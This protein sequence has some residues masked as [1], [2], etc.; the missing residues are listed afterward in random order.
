MKKSKIVFIFLFIIVVLSVFFLLNYRNN[1]NQLYTK[2][3]EVLVS[4]KKNIKLVGNSNDHYEFDIQ[5]D[6]EDSNLIENVDI[7]INKNDDFSC[8]RQK[9]TNKKIIYKCVG[10]VDNSDVTDLKRKI[11]V[12]YKLNNKKYKKKIEIKLKKTQL[13][14]KE[15]HKDKV[16]LESSKKSEL[17][18]TSSV[19]QQIIYASYAKYDEIVA[20]YNGSDGY[21]NNWYTEDSKEDVENYIKSVDHEKTID[22]QNEVDQYVIELTNRISKLQYRLANYELLN[23]KIEEY[24]TSDGYKNNW[25]TE[26]SKED[27]ENYIKS[28]DHEKTI[29]KQNE[30]DQYVIELTNRISKLQYR[31]ANY[32]LLNNKIE[33]YETSDEYK[34]NWYTDDSREEV[35]GYIESFNLNITIDNQEIV[36]DYLYELTNRVARLKL[37]L[38]SYEELNNIIYNYRES[39]EYINNWYTDEDVDSLDKF[40]SSLNYNVTINHQEIVNQ[41]VIEL[42]DRV[43]KL[44]YRLANYE[45]LNNKIE[46]YETSDGYKN[47][48]YTDD[49]RE[50]VEGYI[51]SLDL[52]ITIDNQEI[53]DDYLYELTNKVA[54]LEYKDA[55]YDQLD[56]KILEYHSSDEYINN[57][58]TDESQQIV[59]DFISDIDYNLKINDQ[60]LVDGYVEQLV[61]KIN[62]LQLKSLYIFKRPT[63]SGRITAAYGYSL[64]QFHDGIDIAVPYGMPIYSVGEGVVYRT[65]QN[66]IDGK[67]VV[68]HHIVNGVAYT[69][70][71]SHL[72]AFNVQTG[73]NVSKDTVIGSAGNTGL[74]TA[75]HLHLSITTGRLFIDYNTLNNHTINPYNVI[76]FPAKDESYDKR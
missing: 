40:I 5:F 55:S 73:Q 65:G 7:K 8:I 70:Y 30:V 51:E 45:L 64:G 58:Y 18:I 25:Y 21:K 52:N 44:K 43:S 17:K 15:K 13:R 2:K 66:S 76:D 47:N 11:N 10:I 12:T 68:I 61:E 19:E 3:N 39:Y 32:E 59:D 14:I 42:S 31:L 56:A 57:M 74:S 36:D 49:S 41:Y 6:T 69:S 9:Q 1:N 35:E 46:E 54:R 4:T 60:D 29:D 26:D 16:V 23:N 62:L 72:S 75:T 33:E 34:N 22:K 50:E 27:V 38:A 71:Y 63:T 28:V 24:E 67:F 37:K 53:V 20:K 48:W